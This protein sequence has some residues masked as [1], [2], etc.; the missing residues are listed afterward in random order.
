MQRVL[1]KIS[2]LLFCST[3]S[4]WCIWT[5]QWQQLHL[6]HHWWD[7]LTTEMDR[8]V[9]LCLSFH[10]T[11]LSSRVYARKCAEL[12]H[13]GFGNWA[14]TFFLPNRKVNPATRLTKKVDKS[15]VTIMFSWITAKSC[16]IQIFFQN[17]WKNQCAVILNFEFLQVN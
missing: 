2:P 10:Y 14:R 9:E 16:F 3:R 15:F 6:I 11:K 8:S 1:L 4:K 12:I 17:W 7:S 13:N 5:R